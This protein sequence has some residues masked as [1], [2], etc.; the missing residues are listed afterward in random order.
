MCYEEYIRKLKAI[1]R[2]M[3]DVCPICNKLR[4]IEKS[5]KGSEMYRLITNIKGA[6][7]NKRRTIKRVSAIPSHDAP[8]TRIWNH[9]LDNMGRSFGRIFAKFNEYH[10]K[11]QDDYI[12]DESITL[13]SKMRELFLNLLDC[14]GVP[15]VIDFD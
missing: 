2:F 14:L 5:R 4:L 8:F 9:K 13:A 10:K 3:D 1:E 7:Y 12:S 6:I 11:L 15:F